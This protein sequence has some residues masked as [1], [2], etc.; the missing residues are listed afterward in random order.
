MAGIGQLGCL[1]KQAIYIVA[2]KVHFREPG[3]EH[4]GDLESES[5]AA[6]LGGISSV[7]EMPNTMPPTTTKNTLDDKFRRA[8][9]RMATNY[10]SYL[11]A[12]GY[13]LETLKAARELGACGIK[14]FMGASIRTLLVNGTTWADGHGIPGS[15]RTSRAGRSASVPPG[16]SRVRRRGHSSGPPGC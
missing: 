5:H 1:R 6:V 15:R 13:N 11:G 7:L 14:I 8:D 12:T 10:S 3:H 16:R 4:K 9:G 2:S